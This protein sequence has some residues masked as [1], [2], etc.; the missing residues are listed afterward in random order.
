MSDSK[1]GRWEF[2]Q[3]GNVHYVPPEEQ[4][5]NNSEDRVDGAYRKSYQF[6]STDNHYN[7]NIQK[8]SR[9][10]KSNNDTC[11]IVSNIIHINI[12]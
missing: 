12:T 8:D 11:K 4:S 1:G 6:H 2:D 10:R 9:R 5:G 3:E 7:V